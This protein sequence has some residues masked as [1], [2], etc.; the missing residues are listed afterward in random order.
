MGHE[1]SR[2]ISFGKPQLAWASCCSSS[3][4]CRSSEPSWGAS[5]CSRCGTATRRDHAEVD[6]LIEQ[7]AGERHGANVERM[8]GEPAAV[9]DR[10]RIADHP[11]RE[12]R[13]AVATHA[14]PHTP[15]ERAM[16]AS[17]MLMSF[18]GCA[19]AGSQ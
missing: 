9:I 1:P 7:D 3:P 2:T 14:S 18:S 8:L 16:L 12:L 6:P 4:A 11:Q 17:F 15:V 19:V 5:Q 13:P 10:G